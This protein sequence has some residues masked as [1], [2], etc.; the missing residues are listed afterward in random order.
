MVPILGLLKELITIKLPDFNFLLPLE[1]LCP[2]QVALLA[3]AVHASG[4]V[5]LASILHNNH[6]SYLHLP[7]NSLTEALHKSFFV[8]FPTPLLNLQLNELIIKSYS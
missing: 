5:F 1:L 6:I 2:C 8:T 4:H 7:I 3:S